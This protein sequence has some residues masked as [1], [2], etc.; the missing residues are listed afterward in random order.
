MTTALLDPAPPSAPTTCSA[1]PTPAISPMTLP[2]EL[3]DVFA[4]GRLASAPPQPATRLTLTFING[5]RCPAY[6]YICGWIQCVHGNVI[7]PEKIAAAEAAARAELAEDAA[8]MAQASGG[9]TR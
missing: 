4:P 2:L 3:A 8:D 9:E 5:H 6:G 1:A 7:R